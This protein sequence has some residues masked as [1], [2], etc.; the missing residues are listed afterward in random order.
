MPE[1]KRG[2]SATNSFPL[3]SLLR[4]TR[5][6]RSRM[7][8]HETVALR[9]TKGH[10]VHIRSG[11]ADIFKLEQV[12]NQ[13][14]GFGDSNL[15]LDIFTRPGGGISSGSARFSSSPLRKAK[16]HISKISALKLLSS[17]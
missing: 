13:L 11:A 16:C 4:I 8:N 17:S 14:L 1:K 6:Y 3:G 12:E 9:L 5:K 15:F 10:F 2:A 7:F